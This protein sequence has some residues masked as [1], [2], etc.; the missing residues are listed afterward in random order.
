MS[1][2]TVSHLCIGISAG[3][4][5]AR[6][7]VSK[8]QKS[9]EATVQHR[10]RKYAAPDQYKRN[11]S[12]IKLSIAA[13]STANKHKQEPSAKYF[14]LISLREGDLRRLALDHRCLA[15]MSRFPHV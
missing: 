13:I 10:P 2:L 8:N 15:I 4:K 7:G 11:K 3:E 9:L 12:P 14:T 5:A 1:L 6:Y